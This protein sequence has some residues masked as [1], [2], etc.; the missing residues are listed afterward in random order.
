MK[1]VYILNIMS[2]THTPAYEV[3]ENKQEAEIALANQEKRFDMRKE[4]TE[5]K[6]KVRYGN[7][8]IV[9]YANEYSDKAVPM[10]YLAERPVH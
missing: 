8:L 6:H 3:F 4:I 2:D 7:D 1:K 10:L 9:F 5:S